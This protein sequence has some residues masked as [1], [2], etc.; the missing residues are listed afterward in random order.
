[1][2]CC[3]SQR[4]ATRSFQACPLPSF[5][6]H[7]PQLPHGFL[8]T[9]ESPGC[10]TLISVTRFFSSSFGKCWHQRKHQTCSSYPC[11]VDVAHSAFILPSGMSIII[12]E[13]P[14]FSPHWKVWSTEAFSSQKESC[15]LVA[16]AEAIAGKSTLTC[17]RKYQSCCNFKEKTHPRSFIS[18]S[19]LWAF[20]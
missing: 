8:Q 3:V 13:A 16:T 9:G 18:D 4:T 12:Q 2:T 19:I 14:A 17:R 7:L 15:S 5:L 20:Y 10:L 11:G 6:S 1:M